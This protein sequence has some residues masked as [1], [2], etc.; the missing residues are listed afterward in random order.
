MDA[1]IFYSKS[2]GVYA[3]MSA[4]NVNKMLKNMP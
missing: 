4:E 1:L 3:P 2:K